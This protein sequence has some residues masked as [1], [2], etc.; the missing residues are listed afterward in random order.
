MARYSGE[1]V[2]L[3]AY[4]VAYEMARAPVRELLGQPAGQ[5]SVDPSKHAPRQLFFYKPQ[6][7]RLPPVERLGPHGAVRLD[8]SVKVLQV[9]AVSITVR[10]PFAVDRLEDLVPYHDLRFGKDTLNEEIVRLA[11]DLQK[12][13]AP[14]CIR[15][16]KQLLEAEAYTIFCIQ[17]PLPPP[18]GQE[19][20]ASAETWLQEYRRSIAALLTQEAEAVHLSDQEVL[21]STGRYLSYYDRDLAV[22][23]WDAALLVDQP[24]YFDETLYILE[25]A[26]LHLA[27]LKAY[28]RYLDEALDHSYRDLGR[29]RLR[30]S[31]EMLRE[32]RVI[33]VD[34]AR[35][36]D[37]MSNIGKFFGD[38][39]LARVYECV[40]GRF[41]LQD[42]QKAM[43]EKLRTLDD[44]YEMLQS[45]LNNRWMMILEVTIV[46]LFVLD[47]ALLFL[48]K[49]AGRE[50]GVRNRVIGLV[51][52]ALGV[53]RQRGFY[54]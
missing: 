30:S 24:Q 7:V 46:V 5:F 19:L 21:E 45:D 12:E 34:L 39:H 10:V 54:G 52:G 16:A 53:A 26:N 3:Y 37:E 13:L 18:A 22:V 29:S 17:G 33:R 25:L 48:G 50:N 23:D 32:L 43:D 11:E 49:Y 1:V 20:P 41:H 27:E 6:I 47:I 40:A 2:Y 31:R 38:W 15:P 14:Y 51:L 36:N 35:F 42:W 4:D 28:D 44:L 9:G 8:R